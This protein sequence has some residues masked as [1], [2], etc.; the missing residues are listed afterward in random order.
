LRTL[1]EA[2]A[3]SIPQEHRTRLLHLGLVETGPEGGI[4]TALGRERLIS[5]R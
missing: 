1:S 2:T 5:D 3:P 4:I